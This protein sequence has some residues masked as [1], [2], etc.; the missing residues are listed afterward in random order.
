MLITAGAPADYKLGDQANMTYKGTTF[1]AH[2]VPSRCS[3]PIYAT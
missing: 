2:R 3:V 1:L